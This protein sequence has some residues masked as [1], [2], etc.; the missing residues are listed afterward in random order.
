VVDL[1]NGLAAFYHYEFGV[2]A[3]DTADVGGED[4]GGRLSYVGLQGGF[5]QLTIGRQ[6]N[7][8]YFAVAGEID[9]FNGDNNFDDSV[10]GIDPDTGDILEAADVANLSIGMRH[11]F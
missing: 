3:A 10:T 6:W 1:G 8:Y 7:P 5:G 2:D 9:W 11:D 4:V